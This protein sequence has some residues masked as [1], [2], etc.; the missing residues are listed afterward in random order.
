M[1]DVVD[2]VCAGLKPVRD[3]FSDL[4]DGKRTE[5]DVLGLVQ[6]AGHPTAD[7]LTVQQE[8]TRRVRVVGNHQDLIL[9]RVSQR[10]LIGSQLGHV[11][12]KFCSG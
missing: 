2:P 3:G 6:V 8:V 11:I 1:A 9:S 10:I 4:G 12:V 5:A 7:L